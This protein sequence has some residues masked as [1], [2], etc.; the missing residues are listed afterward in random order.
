MARSVNTE[1]GLE[2]LV[3]FRFTHLIGQ[4]CSARPPPGVLPCS[5]S[6]CWLVRWTNELAKTVEQ[7]QQWQ[8][9]SRCTVVLLRS[10]AYRSHAQA[11]VSRD[12]SK[13][14]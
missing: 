9:I 10:I 5:T 14:L 11:V 8:G 2:I 3:L 4:R 7:N 6:I 12:P 13:T 1:S